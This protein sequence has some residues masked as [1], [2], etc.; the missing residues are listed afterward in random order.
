MAK[1]IVEY[2]SIEYSIDNQISVF[3][4]GLNYNDII[5]NF[6]NIVL[7]ECNK[8]CDTSNIYENENGFI[9]I[10]SVKDNLIFGI[11]GKSTSIEKSVLKRIRDSDGNIISKTDLNLENY[12]YFLANLN[13][14]SC[15]VLR[16]TNAPSFKKLFRIFLLE[17]VPY[18]S[19]KIDIYPTLDKEYMS[20]LKQFKSLKNINMVFK[21]DSTTI[22]SMLSMKEIFD[23][24][25]NSLEKVSL[26]LSYK[27]SPVSDAFITKIS[28]QAFMNDSFEKFEIKSDD[29]VIEVINN[30]LIKSIELDMTQ[31]SETN[32]ENYLEKIRK[33]L[34]EC[35]N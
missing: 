4:S 28:N 15:V 13:T 26:S 5:Q 34:L 35:F 8:L 14:N 7:T 24:S 20:K 31:D 3:N 19:F 32:A 6:I 11:L 16:N 2:Y 30:L 10:F 22:D 29:E 12:R 33:A 18:N 25:N 27:N 1:V 17:K 23:L 21:R 9:E